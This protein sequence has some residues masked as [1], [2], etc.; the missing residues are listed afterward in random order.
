[1][2]N[3]GQIFITTDGGAIWTSQTSPTTQQLNSIAAINANQL[4]ACGN[5]GTIINTLSGGN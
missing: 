2:G 1:V 4:W 5:T 3:N